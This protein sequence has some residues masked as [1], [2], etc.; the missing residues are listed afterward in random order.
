[1]LEKTLWALVRCAIAALLVSAFQTPCVAVSD[2]PIGA[3]ISM[4][5][6]AITLGEPVT[7]DYVIS[8]NLMEEVYAELGE[9][10]SAWLSVKVGGVEGS[11]ARKAPDHRPK[12]GGGISAPGARVQAG[13]SYRGTLVLTRM[14]S[15]P[16]PG[17]YRVS[18][19]V[20]LP[21][22]LVE[23][24]ASGVLRTRRSFDLLV[25][26]MDPKRLDE[27]ARS[28]RKAALEA[29][30]YTEREAAIQAL[31]SMPEQRVLP[32]WRALAG[33]VPYDFGASLVI[34]ELL[35]VGSK[36]A[37]DILAEMWGD[38]SRLPQ[39]NSEARIALMNM[40]WMGDSGLKRHV[41]A[42]FT[43]HG[44]KMPKISGPILRID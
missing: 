39:I 8:N 40:W 35:R 36:N 1:M 29:K 24:G 37:A 21:Y 25:N 12:G 27:T 23:A 10:H 19:E 15:I 7:L 3:S 42:L 16:K 31:F 28:L 5:N 26:K 32:Q 33:E 4:R 6:R 2:V 9:D 43:A 22:T 14:F 41:E 30:G 17:K 11:G 13:R 34:D 38:R 44:E 18:I 20:H